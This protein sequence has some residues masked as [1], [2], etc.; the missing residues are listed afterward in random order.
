MK[1]TSRQISISIRNQVFVSPFFIRCIAYV[2]LFHTIS[3]APPRQRCCPI[4]IICSQRATALLQCS[5]FSKG[6]RRRGRRKEGGGGS[7][8]CV[9]LFYRAVCMLQKKNNAILLVT[10]VHWGI[11]NL[12][13]PSVMHPWVTIREVFIETLSNY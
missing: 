6:R 1:A 8:R 9:V 2:L 10:C 13:S 3:R 7:S 12:C 11:A 4:S 5:M